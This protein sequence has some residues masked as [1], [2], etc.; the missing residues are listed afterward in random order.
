[1]NKSNIKIIFFGTSDFAVPTLET[2]VNDGYDIIAVI[3]NPDEP[4]GRNKTLTP[5]P[6]KIAAEKLN[7]DVWQP[8]NLKL[9]N[10]NFIE[11]LVPSMPRDWK[12]KIENCDLGVVAAYG[13]FIPPE[14]IELS[15]HGILNIHPSLLPQYRGPSP[16]QY[17]LLSGD[18]TTGVTIIKI[19]EEMDHGP[20]VANYKIQISNDKKFIELHDELAKLGAEMLVKILPDYLEGKIKPTAQNHSV[21]TFT[22]LI[23]TAD[24]EIKLN[25]SAQPAYNKIRALNPEPGTFVITSGKRLQ[26]LEA[27]ISDGR[28]K[29]K[30]VQLEG[31]KPMSAEDFSKG[32]PN[33]LPKWE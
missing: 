22:K 6:V 12:S 2:L 33:L 4:A 19:D 3:T 26:I 21:A 30:K 13:K 1:M 29:I 32:H 15:K 24:G 17:A 10:L 11:K 20:I 16:I 14:I 18:K 25:D 23:K 9:A 27:A 7:L 31:S 8:K 5:P 28:L